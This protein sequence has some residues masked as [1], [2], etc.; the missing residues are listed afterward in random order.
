MRLNYYVKPYENE[1]YALLVANNGDRIAHY[2]QELVGKKYWEQEFMTDEQK[3][4]AK[5]G[6]SKGKEFSLQK[7]LL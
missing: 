4:I 1:G 7:N 5:E 2:S 6:I 3:I